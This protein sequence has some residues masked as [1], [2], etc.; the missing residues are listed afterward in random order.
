[1]IAS[2]ADPSQVSAARRAAADF[3]RASGFDETA[4]GRIA[5]VATEMATNLLKHASAGQIVIGSF[6]D[7][8]GA[9]LELMSLDKG[10]GIADLGRAFEDGYSTRGVRARG[11]A[12]CAA[13]AII[14]PSGRGLASAL[15]RSRASNRK[16]RPAASRSAPWGCLIKGR[17]FPAMPGASAHPRQ[18]R[19]C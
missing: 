4:T 2:I 18:G 3:A 11:W 10:P 19:R 13:R 17:R 5:I 12:R 14:S 9:G 7:C 6:A 1:V 8:D 16:A 15:R